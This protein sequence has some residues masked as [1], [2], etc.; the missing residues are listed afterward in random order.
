MKPT[1]QSVKGTREFYPED[2]AAR[3]WL[4][5]TI[6]EISESF[7]YEEWDGPFL[8]KID[9]Y[10]AK[11]GEE[12]VKEQSF[13]FE[14]RGG[15]PVTLRPELTPSL[16]RMIAQR[17]NQLIFPLRWWSFGPFWRYERPQ[18][19]RTREFFQWNIDLMGADSPEADA[20]LISVAASFLERVGYRPG[21]VQI[22]VNNRELMDTVLSDLGIPKEMRPS[23]FKLIDKKAKL[24]SQGW[25]DYATEIGLSDQQFTGLCGVLDD[26]DLWKQSFAMVRVFKGIEAYGL[27]DYVRFDPMIIR[28]LDYYT[29][30]VFEAIHLTE[31]GRSILGGGRYDNLVADVGGTPLG[32]VGFAMGDVMIQVLLREDHLLPSFKT[33]PA[34]VMVAVF[35]METQLD[36]IQLSSTIR[37]ER[38]NVITFPEQAKLARQFKYADR[39]GIRYVVLA[40][41]EEIAQNMF[42]LKDLA[43]GEQ[44]TFPRTELVKIIREKLATG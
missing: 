16:A 17:Q 18:K 33:V 29:G 38:I 12:L 35:N 8:E 19:G 11:S 7:G 23:I 37:H 22:R 1:I 36:A 31:G 27:S 3:R 30:T 14:D 2:M 9:L 10:A 28:G 43:S 32:G 40:G 20:E 39:L 4:Y 13:V 41:P 34:R 44:Q 26:P 15:D 21:Q 24:S 25:Q 42:A 5:Q 6:R